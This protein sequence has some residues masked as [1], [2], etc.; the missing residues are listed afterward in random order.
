M[1]PVK[2]GGGKYTN[3]EKTHA[4]VRSEQRANLMQLNINDIDVHELRT[5]AR[6]HRPNADTQLLQ[7][8]CRQHER[9]LWLNFHHGWV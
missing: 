1:T 3:A 4:C 8:A 6:K 9:F 7:T 5:T 2:S